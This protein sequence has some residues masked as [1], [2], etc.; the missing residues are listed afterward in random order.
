M[1]EKQPRPAD[2]ILDEITARKGKGAATRRKFTAN[3]ESNWLLALTLHSFAKFADNVSLSDLEKS[4]VA[5]FRGKGFSDDEIKEH[6]R[7]G[8][9]IT[10]QLR[11]EFFAPSFAQLDTGTSYSFNDLKRDADDI[12][13]SILDKPNVTQ[14]D[15]PAIHDGKAAL[16]DF[17]LAPRGVLQ[18]TGSAMLVA[19]EADSAPSAAAAARYTIKATKFR[20]NDRASDAIFGPSNEPYWIFGSL[21]QGSAVTTRSKVFGDVDS[22]EK[23]TF[24]PDDGCIWGQNCS[25]QD[26]PNGEVA[27]LVQLWEHDSGNPEKI[28]KGVEAAFGAA[29]VILAASGVAAWVSAVVAGVGAVIKWLPRF[30]DDDHIADQ[31]F[32]FSKGVVAKNLP[33][34]G[35]HFDV[36]RRFADGDADYTLTIAVT[37]VA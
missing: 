14:I 37:R 18:E 36:T 20:C 3:K 5:S 4:I 24:D 2:R 7:L 1:A 11:N 23:R 33:R 35:N 29:A 30:L 13:K 31:T 6:G 22:G 34:V 9:K 19:L 26:L 8:K 10:K 15:V 32:V 28:R 12:V 27:S 21:G 25:A 16:K 17:S